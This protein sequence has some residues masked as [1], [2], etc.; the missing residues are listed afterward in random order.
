MAVSM[1]LKFEGPD[2]PGESVV[3]GH[4][5]EIDVINF[6]WSMTQ[7]GTAHTGTGAGA[8]KVRVGNM[9]IVKKIDKASAILMQSV[10]TG[11]HFA[12]A[13]LKC[14]K[15]GGKDAVEYFKVT[16]SNVII[17]EFDTK[18]VPTK[19]GTAGDFWLGY[20]VFDEEGEPPIYMGE[21]GDDV[22]GESISL[23][24]SQVEVVYTPQTATG[25]KGTEIRAAYDIAKGKEL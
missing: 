18:G 19:C 15:A 3:E 17:S 16:M 1:F 5:D 11:Q 12:V 13:T 23:N 14:Y 22:V 4:E 24:F 6:K 8:G 10:S 25:V 7:S 20:G 9:L 2:L 21:V